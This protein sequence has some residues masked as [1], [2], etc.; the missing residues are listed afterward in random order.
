MSICPFWTLGNIPV[1]SL[2]CCGLLERN[3]VSF[4]GFIWIE[5]LKNQPSP[6]PEPKQG[7]SYYLSHKES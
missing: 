7:S 5:A 2:N 4:K 6:T 3:G 1:D